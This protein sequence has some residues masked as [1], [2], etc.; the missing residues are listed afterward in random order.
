MPNIDAAE[1]EFLRERSKSYHQLITALKP[2][3]PSDD[4][5]LYAAPDGVKSS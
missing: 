1:L 5:K 2:Y 3:M 4:H